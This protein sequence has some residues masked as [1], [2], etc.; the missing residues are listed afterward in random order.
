MK[1]IKD[2]RLIALEIIDQ[3]SE[4]KIHC[5]FCGKK[6]LLD[7]DEIKSGEPIEHEYCK[8]ITFHSTNHGIEYM[9]EDIKE[10]NMDIEMLEDYLESGDS[11][12]LRDGIILDD[13][14][15][16]YYEHLPSPCSDIYWEM[17]GFSALSLHEVNNKEILNNEIIR[18]NE[19]IEKGVN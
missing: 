10:S 2:M 19:L 8:H 17:I 9:R 18:H 1:K 6:S 5:M 13:S 15:V 16:V 4:E 11:E 3:F 12:R 7:M 14:F